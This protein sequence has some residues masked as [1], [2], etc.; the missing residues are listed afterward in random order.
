MGSVLPYAVRE[1]A[2]DDLEWLIH[3]QMYLK[4]IDVLQLEYTPMA[5][6]R[7]AYHRIATALFEHDV[8]FQSVARGLGFMA[9]AV[10]R[11]K[12]RV[13]YLR[14]LRYELGA[15]EGF[16]QVQVC[17]RENRDYLASF[18][19]GMA[20]RVKEGLRAGIDTSRYDFKPCGREPR[21]MLFLGSFRHDPNR[22]ALDWFV[23][24]VLP[25]ILAS[26]PD[27]RLVVAGSDPPPPH[28]YADHAGSL[29]LVGY[30]EDVREPLSRYAVFVC[31]ILSGSGV[32]VKLL[33]AFAAGIPV[34]S[35]RV[36]AEGLAHEDGNWCALADD[37]GEFAAKVVALLN[38]E[39][40]AAAMAR[41]ARAGV[42]A[43]WDMAA[44]THKL[45]DGYRELVWSARQ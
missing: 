16:D 38:D 26:I 2:N 39:A 15:L 8:Y 23:G 11:L 37:P 40:V 13:E 7:G 29:D 32:R 21:T 20:G 25:R 44:V 5:Q 41:R 14:A 34:V 45:A 19:P 31:P 12:A 22:I 18:L 28:A 9:G 6:Y 43:D 42:E 10:E 30:V 1:F 4:K 35:T 27:A 3:R 17:T 33:E 24:H 36:G